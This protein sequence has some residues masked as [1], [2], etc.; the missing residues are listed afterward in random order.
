MSLMTFTSALSRFS[1]SR[2]SV[3]GPFHKHVVVRFCHCSRG[4]LAEEEL[5]RPQR[6]DGNFLRSFRRRPR[7]QSV[8]ASLRDGCAH[9]HVRRAQLRDHVL[10]CLREHLQGVVGEEAGRKASSHAVVCR[11]EVTTA[12]QD[13]ARGEQVGEAEG[14]MTRDGIVAQCINVHGE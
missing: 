7:R 9:R 10:T 12:S 3:L 13:Q 5:L 14:V 8:H 4:G 6:S 2:S 11:V 1:T